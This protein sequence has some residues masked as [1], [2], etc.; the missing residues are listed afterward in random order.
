MLMQVLK[1]LFDLTFRRDVSRRHPEEDVGR[2]ILLL[3]PLAAAVQ[4]QGVLAGVSEGV[5]ALDGLPE[6]QVQRGVA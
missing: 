5:Q 3:E 1:A 4:S 6:G 2:R